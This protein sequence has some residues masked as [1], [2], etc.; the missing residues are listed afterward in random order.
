MDI[1]FF[2]LQRLKGHGEAVN[3]LRFH[4]NDPNILLSVSKGGCVTHT[5]VSTHA[6]FPSRL[7]TSHS[8]DHTLRLWNVKT[9]VCIA[10]FGGVEGHRDEVLSGVSARLHYSLSGSSPTR[11]SRD[12]TCVFLGL[13]FRR[14]THRIWWDGSLTQDLEVGQDQH[15]HC[16]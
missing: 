12:V 14:R 4:P 16:Y 1:F 15:R 11:S 6:H 5:R 9:E 3:E 2:I 7:T 10:L 8:A 13:Q